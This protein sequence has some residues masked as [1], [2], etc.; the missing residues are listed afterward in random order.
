MYL[1]GTMNAQA[2]VLEEVTV[3]AQKREQSLQDVGIS[4]TAYSGEQLRTLGFNNAVD[5]VVQTPGL[6]V[7]G[8]GGGTT[9]SFSIRGVSQNDFA[10]SQESAVAVYLNDAYIA[11]NSVVNFSLFDIER[12]EVLRGPQGTLFGR[13]ATGG[14]VHYITEK[15]SQEFSGFIDIE[16]GEDGRRRVE[17]AIGGAISENVS[18][19]LSGIYKANS[20]LISNDIGP[21][22]MEEDDYSIRAQLLF[23]PDEDLSVLLSIQYAEE[24]DVKGGYSHVVAFD[25]QASSDSTATD[26]FGYRDA[27]GDPFT[28]SNDFDNYKVAEV[29]DVSAKID[30][31]LGRYTL[32]SV[33]NLQNIEDGYGEDADVS[34]VDVYNFEKNNDVDQ[35]SQELRLGWEGENYNAVL[36]F[37][38]LEIDGFYNTDQTGDVFF[39]GLTETASADQETTTW[40]VFGQTEIDLTNQLSATLGIRYNKDEKEFLYQSTNIFGA[41]PYTFA[42]KFK[43]DDFSAKIQLNYRPNEDWLWYAGVNRGIKSGG[44]NFPLFPIADP[45]LYEFQGETLMA[46]EAGFKANLND[47]TR[48][49][50]AAYYY[51]YE[52]HQ[53]YSFDGFATRLLNANAESYGA[54][55]ELIANPVDG[56][57]I[58]LGVAINDNEI[59]DVPLNASPDGTEEAVITPSLSFNGLLRYSWPAFNGSLAAQLDGSWR[60]SQNFNLTITPAVQEGSYGLLNARLSYATADAKWSA[61]VFVRNL[62][63]EYYRA[64]SFDTSGFFGSLEDIPGIP[65]WI[66]G[67]VSYNW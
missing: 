13:N 26:Y 60:D 2:Q 31:A 21:D 43:E 66:G 54:E 42:D 64:Y 37:Y 22:L 45:A 5:V 17:G 41:A 30:W 57:D 28:A 12:V 7:S 19:R 16:L 1:L 34:P 3:T 32:T 25:G 15:P 33:T 29:L 49:N 48:L 55:I 51:D 53:V 61:A 65:R 46:Y 9:N 24:D 58:L 56:L 18:G 10:S 63:D 38:F 20:G 6:Q 67:S 59:T 62:T 14:L 50:A 39:G 44:H 11:L 27:D 47:T 52:D 4:V 36:G 35:I 40:A 23:E 8:A